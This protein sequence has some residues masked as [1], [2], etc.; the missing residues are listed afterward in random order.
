[1]LAAAA[2]GLVAV[3]FSLLLLSVEA[4]WMPLEPVPLYLTCDP[5]R[6]RACAGEDGVEQAGISV[7]Q[8]V[9]SQ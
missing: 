1:V 7:V 6:A 3:P 5:G 9:A 2:L 4:Q 8:V